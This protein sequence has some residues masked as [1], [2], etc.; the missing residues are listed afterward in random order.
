MV[1]LLYSFYRAGLECSAMGY[2]VTGGWLPRHKYDQCHVSV[3]LPL[4]KFS[5]CHI[6]PMLLTIIL[7][8]SCSCHLKGGS[9]VQ[10][11]S[12][13]NMGI[14][15]CKHDMWIQCK[16]FKVTRYRRSHPIICDTQNNDQYWVLKVILAP[17]HMWH[18][19]SNWPEKH[20]NWYV[21]YWYN[22]YWWMDLFCLELQ[23]K[24]NTD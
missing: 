14:L 19:P 18:F 6:V 11:N 1:K 12:M 23:W 15:Q 20:S 10:C 16:W 24:W 8:Q 2:G 21:C 7:V 5:I 3:V 17:E 22:N 9:R 13:S 4:Y